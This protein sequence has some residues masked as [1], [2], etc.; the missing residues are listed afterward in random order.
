MRLVAWFVLGEV[1]PS[2]TKCDARHNR[3]SPL[4]RKARTLVD[5]VLYEQ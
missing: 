3:R 5:T 4:R 1:R 2:L